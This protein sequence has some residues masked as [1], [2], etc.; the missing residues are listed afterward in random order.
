MASTQPI[1]TAQ[2][3]RFFRELAR[4]NRKEWMDQNRQRYQQHV[5]APFRALLDRLAPAAL[6]LNAHFDVSG[7]TGVNF[8]RINRD[9]R[10]SK[11]KS[12]YR[13]QMYLYFSDRRVAD[14]DAQLYVG[15]A[16]EAVT[17]GVRIYGGER[18]SRLVR[19][20]APRALANLKWLA[21]QARRLGR[22]YDS[23]WYCSEKGDW[24]QRMGF[25]LTADDWQRIRG[26]VVR[27]KWR[28]AAALR[29]AFAQDAAKV[30]SE[31]FPLY[32]FL[33]SDR[34]PQ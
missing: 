11:D 7:R 10:F 15:A 32:R 14:G 34:W 27:K 21:A 12:P 22:K 4:N 26:W 9:I 31:V 6:R 3:F 2:T 28:P 24:R 23:Y 19:L 5:V 29:A 8:S 17:V 25:P 20:A 16:A 33:S 13:P 30:F 18:D 1:F